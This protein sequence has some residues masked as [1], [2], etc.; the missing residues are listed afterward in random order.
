[1]TAFY[2]SMLWS[3]MA[4]RLTYVL[5]H[6]WQSTAFAVIA[7]LLTMLLRTNHARA[8]YWIWFAASAKFLIPFAALT[9]L[10]RQLAWPNMHIVRKLT[11][12]VIEVNMAYTPLIS[13]PR[14]SV[15][16]MMTDLVLATRF[17]WA[18]LFAIWFCGFAGVA[19]VWLRRWRSVSAAVQQAKATRDGREFEIL[20]RVQEVCG[21]R[22]SIRLAISSASFEPGVFGIFRPVMLLPEGIADRLDDTQLEAIFAHELCHA[23]SHD[24]LAAAFHMAIQAIFWF[25]PLVWWLGSRLVDERERACDEEVLRLGNPP[26]VYAEGIL[27]VCKF[28]VESPLVCVAGVT[29]SNLK[30]RI[31]GIMT[32]RMATQLDAGRKLL[33]A[34]LGVAAIA[35]PLV[36]GLLN[37]PRSRAQTPSGTSS[38]KTYEAAS[39]KP[40]DPNERRA[41]I[42]MAPG[43]RVNIKNLPV[44]NL[45]MM[46]YQLRDFQVT[47]GP[48]WM[49]TD[50]YDIVAK[51]DD[52][53]ITPEQNREMMQNLLKDRFKLVFHNETKELPVYNLVIGKNGPK[54]RETPESELP[55]PP[56]GNGGARGP[57][58]GRASIRIERGTINGQGMSMDLLANQLANNLGRSVINMTGLTKGY[59]IKLEWTP[60]VGQGGALQR[61]GGADS[62]PT[63]A[64]SGPTI[65]TAL[66]EQLGLK[67]ESAKGPVVIY[68]I[69]SLQR[70]SEN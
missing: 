60:D 12:S 41:Q 66:Q 11:F 65:F 59:D 23:R 49:R 17:A 62:A 61:D 3:L 24:N 2:I 39:I 14:G 15:I 38:S 48:D 68:I 52:E 57:L 53:N 33:L 18:I 43:G 36:V 46:A 37:P 5:D 67:L 58:G 64:E 31:E 28:Y 34:A 63:T 1:M 13:P 6:L 42:M 16:P 20:R 4:V 54:L 10:G 70:P 55:P 9:A 7:L 50:R 21:P 32:H 22:Q 26:Q 47:G 35:G 29:G 45:I 27:K 56:P 8:R 30:K 69:D 19:F 40:G 25:H 51:A 44:R